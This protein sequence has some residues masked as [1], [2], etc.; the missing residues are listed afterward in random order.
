MRNLSRRERSA[1]G[2]MD[3]SGDHPA[4]THGLPGDYLF[5]LM[6]LRPVASGEHD[7]AIARALVSDITACH[8]GTGEDDT[9][10]APGALI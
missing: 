1:L 5:A 9:G 8:P 2:A 10:F 3:H 7:A 6:G 4:S